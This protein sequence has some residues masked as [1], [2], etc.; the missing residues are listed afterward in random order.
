[1][2]AIE[3]LEL[4]AGSR[5]IPNEPA[6]FGEDG[7][8]ALTLTPA[9]SIKVRPVRWLWDGRVALG[10]LALMGGREGIGKST[11]C[12]QIAADITRGRLT[13]AYFGDP[14]SVVVAATEDSWEHTIV[15]RLMAAGADLDRIYRV[16]VTTSAGFHGSLNLPGDLG[17]L[18]KL[19]T[20]ADAAMVL[21]DPLMSRLD[22]NLDTHK[23]ADVRQALEP[24]VALAD[25]CQIALLGLIH[26]N[27][28]TT[29]DPLTM[30][31]A[32]RAFAAVARAV[33]F[34]TVDPESEQVRILGQPK[35]NL[36]RTD[37]PSLTF[38]IEGAVVAET[39]EGQV[40]TARL[41]WRGE[42]S[43]SIDDV[44]R[45][46]AESNDSRSATQ[47]A[48]AWLSDFLTMHK[49]ASSKEIKD[50]G[51]ADGHGIDALKR[52]RQ[53]IGAGATAHGF[54]RRTYWSAPTLTPDDV[55]RILV[56]LSQSEQP[57]R[58]SHGESALTALTAPTGQSEPQSAQ[59]E[60]SV[61]SPGTRAN[62]SQP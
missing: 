24:L 16:D 20:E 44:L 5:S 10:T 15:P 57:S 2:S 3:R 52:A 39:D 58:S 22:A 60:Q 29:T 6:A 17:E 8:R 12:Y 19:I 25:R 34:V 18:R 9:S 53:K 56:D 61:E 50:A 62:R 46:A 14:R 11:V 38:T 59:S 33:L 23:D 7:H 32:S 26:L 55:D 36:G 47:E 13:G 41:V 42:T 51:K 4:P 31:M 49:V 28:S 45:T 21:L 27:K 30:L 37:L 48:A 35:N 54:P 43:R 1:V 40:W